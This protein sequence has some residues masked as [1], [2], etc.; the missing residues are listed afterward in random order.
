E[1]GIRQGHV[2]VPS[3][4]VDYV[5]E[6]FDHFGDKTVLVIGA[7]KMGE[8][9]LHQLKAL[10][11]K[12]ILVTNR[13]PETA[14]AVASRCG[15]EAVPWERL[16]EAL[17]RADIILSTTG[18]PEPIVPRDRYARVASRRTGG[19]VVILDIAVPR[20]FD[21]GVHDGSQTFLLNIDDLEAMSEATLAGRRAHIRAAEQIVE[22]ETRRFTKE[23]ARRRN[24]PV[25][26]QLTRW[27][28]TRRQ[29]AVKHVLSRL[30]G[31]L[32]DADCAATEKAFS[33]FQN[34]LL[35]GPIRA[36]TEEIHAGAAGGYTL[37]EALH[38]LF[39]LPD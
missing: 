33:R 2:S 12:R 21:S 32:S 27:C 18:A 5:R 24:G 38:K 28:E 25:I 13:S 31:K 36:L 8:L 16:D 11:P 14:G 37:V 9:T 10:Q 29:E 26:E 3:A 17:A 23:W 22:Q 19:L 6:V 4:A 15:G 7:G 30:R 34:Q 35:H 39:P 20:D 1:T